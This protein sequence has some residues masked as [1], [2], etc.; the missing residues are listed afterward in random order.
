MHGVVK[1]RG[2]NSLYSLKELPEDRDEL[3]LVE[4]G[5]WITVPPD[6]TAWPPEVT[7]PPPPTVARSKDDPK[8]FRLFRLAGDVEPAGYEPT[9]LSYGGV[10]T[11]EQWTRTVKNIP[12]RRAFAAIPPDPPGV[13]EEAM[14]SMRENR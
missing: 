5:A 12:W 8:K 13:W 2:L 14:R 4:E 9:G 3:D 6:I 11:P 1:I 7:D 10:R